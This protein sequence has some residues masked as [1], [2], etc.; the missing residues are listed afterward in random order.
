MERLFSHLRFAGH[1]VLG[2][3]IRS[4]PMKIHRDAQ[5][6]KETGYF[7]EVIKEKKCNDSS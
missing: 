4:P 3:M 1:D 2:H 7:L 6:K 5:T